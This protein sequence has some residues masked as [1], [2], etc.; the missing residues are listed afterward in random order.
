[1]TLLRERAAAQHRNADAELAELRDRVARAELQVKSLQVDLGRM[2][3]QA[4]RAGTVIYIP[5]PRDEKKKVGDSTWR[6]EKIMEIADIERLFAQGEVDEA[7]A[8]L[9]AVGQALTLRLEA[10]PDSEFKAQVERIASTVT[11]QSASNANRV[12]R[13]EI[14][15]AQGDPR[16][17]RPGMRFRGAIERGRVRGAIVIPLRAVFPGP[18][19]YRRD[20][21]AAPLRLG[22]RGGERV[23]VLAGL[24]A[25]DEVRLEA[26]P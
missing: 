16:R 4:P 21:R 20:G 8:A 22:Q 26:A 14:A 17:L 6:G 7:D 10:H 3:V 11:R 1:M 2:R 19:A 9:V 24:A 25:G 13:L 12:V 18:V 15:L 5:N 23:E